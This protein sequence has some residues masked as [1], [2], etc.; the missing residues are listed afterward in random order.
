MFKKFLS[1]RDSL[2]N[3]NLT[4]NSIF[5]L[6]R[7][8]EGCYVTWSKDPKYNMMV[9]FQ[10]PQNRTF[11]CQYR[12]QGETTWQETTPLKQ[13]EYHMTNLSVLWFDLENLESGRVYE[14]R[15]KGQSNV[16]KF[17]TMPETLAD[18]TINILMMSDNINYREDWTRNVFKGMSVL[19]DSNPDV[20][21]LNGDIV[22]DD[23]IRFRNWL[24]FWKDWFRRAYDKDGCMIPMVGTIG[25]HEGF[26]PN[27]NGDFSNF[28]WGAEKENVP[29]FYS[30][31]SNLDDDGKGVTD[32]GDYLTLVY[33]NSGHTKSIEDQTEWLE[34]TLEVRNDGRTI[35]P[36]MHVS[37]YPTSYTTGFVVDDMVEEW[38]PLFTEYGVKVAG[39]GHNHVSMV[40]KKVTMNDLDDNGVI[41]TGQGAGFGTDLRSS[42]IAT[43][44]WYVDFMRDNS[45]QED[46][47]R[48]VDVIE[49]TENGI[50]IIKKDLNGNTVYQKEL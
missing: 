23:G 28:L 6:S 48:G 37:P 47:V 26:I 11:D 45:Y 30:F 50:K 9:H 49:V 16:Y 7:V 20:V 38:T 22:H 21:V 18:K 40:T 12:L 46:Q 14:T 31:F 43:D 34:Q 36:F 1:I 5:N 19:R 39:T 4:Q 29:F 25:N 2:L 15:L 8:E 24:V 13:T 17:K 41:Y 42:A 3:I 27:D 33:L 44:T 35:I 32:V 10:I